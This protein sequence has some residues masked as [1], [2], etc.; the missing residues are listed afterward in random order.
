MIRYLSGSLMFFWQYS[1]YI[2]DAILQTMENLTL[3]EETVNYLCHDF[4]IWS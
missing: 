2:G 4:I 3:I 1:A